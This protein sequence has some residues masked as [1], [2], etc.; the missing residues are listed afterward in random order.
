MLSIIQ[1]E[2]SSSFLPLNNPALE[3]PVER[4]LLVTMKELYQNLES[5]IKRQSQ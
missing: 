3:E 4:S 2:K 1:K 5:S